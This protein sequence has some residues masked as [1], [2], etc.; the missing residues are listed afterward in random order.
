[1]I[2]GIEGSFR[3]DFGWVFPTHKD[4]KL[5]SFNEAKSMSYD[6]VQAFIQTNVLGHF[7][8]GKR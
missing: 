4:F 7:K 3:T 5:I 2:I 8:D 6:N 1:M